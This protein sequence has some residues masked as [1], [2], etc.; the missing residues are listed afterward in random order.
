MA[1]SLIATNGNSTLV[2]IYFADIGNIQ[3]AIPVPIFTK[4]ALN[5]H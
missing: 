1:K 4:N 5:L 2:L 3:H